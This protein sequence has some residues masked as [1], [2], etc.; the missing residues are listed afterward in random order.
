MHEKDD[1]KKGMEMVRKEVSDL[2]KDKSLAEIEQFLAGTKADFIENRRRYILGLFYIRDHELFRD[3][4][5]FKNATFDEY[6]ER[7]HNIRRTRFDNELWAHVFYPEDAK[8]L[9]VGNV[10][11]I[12]KDCGRLRVAGVINKITLLPSPDQLAIN[13]IIKKEKVETAQPTR[14]KTIITL[15]VYERM[16]TQKNDLIRSLQQE[17]EKKKSQIKR[18]KQALLKYRGDAA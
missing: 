18:L 1:T 12:R 9:G 17:V 6:L 16:L 3:D 7:R 10:V 11:K 15:S 14:P 13:E 8:K 5:V 2:F 4:P